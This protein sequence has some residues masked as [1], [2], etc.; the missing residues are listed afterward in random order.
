MPQVS[1][2]FLQIASL[3]GGDTGSIPVRDTKFIQTL[4]VTVAAA[5]ITACK[6]AGCK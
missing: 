3:H 5:S 1:F 4:T 6:F 2:E